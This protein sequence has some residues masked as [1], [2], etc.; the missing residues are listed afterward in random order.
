[1]RRIIA[2]PSRNVFVGIVA[3]LS[4]FALPDH[5]SSPFAPPSLKK[6]NVVIMNAISHAVIVS[7][8]EKR[9]VDD[10]L[11]A[12]TDDTMTTSW[13]PLMSP[14][15]RKPTVCAPAATETEAA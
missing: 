13:P 6:E 3:W 7:T 12:S 15:W 11:E 14:L 9:F 10:Q 5:T 1:M 8:S 2:T 4:S